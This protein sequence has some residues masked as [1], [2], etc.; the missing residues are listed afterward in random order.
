MTGTQRRRPNL[1][2]HFKAAFFTRLG[3]STQNW[4]EFE[5]RLREQILSQDV[6]QVEE[7]RYGRKFVVQG[8]LTGPSGETVQLVSVWVILEQEDVL[9]FVTAYPGRR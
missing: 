3:Y 7:S 9:R 2:R 6:A 5:Q 1:V 8:P 4:E